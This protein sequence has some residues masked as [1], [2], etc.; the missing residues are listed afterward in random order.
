M[1]FSRWHR[2]SAPSTL[3]AVGRR[4]TS[5]AVSGANDTSGPFHHPGRRENVSRRSPGGIRPPLDSAVAATFETRVVRQSDK[6]FEPLHSGSPEDQI[7]HRSADDDRGRMHEARGSLLR[8]LVH[9]HALLSRLQRLLQAAESG[10]GAHARVHARGADVAAVHRVR[11]S[12]RSRA[13]AQAERAT[14]GAAARRSR[15]ENRYL[16]KDGS[17]RWFLWNAAPDTDRRSSTRSRATSPS[18]S[19]PRRSASAWCDS[20]RPRSPKSRRCRRSCRS[21]RTAGRSATTRIT[22]STVESYISAHTT[23][24][25]QPRHLPRLL[26]HRGRAAMERDGPVRSL[27]GR[28]CTTATG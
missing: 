6:G 13:H 1:S 18:A 11:A 16:C 4:F 17:Y 21:A 22:G 15:F 25:V 28:V 27:P 24:R 23:T 12:R 3:N 20:S 7:T 14:C 5:A 19:R 10:M 8:D 2:L 9:R 26:R